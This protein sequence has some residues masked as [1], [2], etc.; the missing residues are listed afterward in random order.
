MIK[1]IKDAL[2]GQESM[3]YQMDLKKEKF[4]LP[5]VIDTLQRD[6]DQT[7]QYHKR[8][9][10]KHLQILSGARLYEL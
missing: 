1:S 4:E 8:D 3:K 5:P 7:Q 9:L 6:F 10:S 2:D